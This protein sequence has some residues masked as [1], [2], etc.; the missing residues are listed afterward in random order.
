MTVK[1]SIV[2]IHK[3]RILDEEDDLTLME[4]C[5]ICHA[6]PEGVIEMVNEGILEPRGIRM[7]TWRFPFPAVERVRKVQH[8]QHD[9]GVNLAGA[10]LALQL[11]DRIAELE[12]GLKH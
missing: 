5:R 12:S 10:A 7:S 3:G 11:L 2:K 1:Y 9:L 4:L 8:F 6:S